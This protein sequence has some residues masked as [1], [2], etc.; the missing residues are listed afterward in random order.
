MPS[1]PMGVCHAED[2]CASYCGLPS[3]LVVRWPFGLLVG[4]LVG[5]LVGLV[6]GDD[7]LWRLGLGC[8][9]VGG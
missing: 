3:G 9:G 7:G 4:W 1:C 5:W 6:P 2:P 8:G